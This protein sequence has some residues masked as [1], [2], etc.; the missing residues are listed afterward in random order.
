MAKEKNLS[1]LED[2]LILIHKVSQK[3]KQELL[4]TGNRRQKSKRN[5]GNF[6]TTERQ[7]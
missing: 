3:H 5:S 6:I 2:I 4:K 1:E 7:K